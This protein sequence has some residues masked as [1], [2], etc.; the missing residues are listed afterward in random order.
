MGT[1]NAATRYQK[2]SNTTVVPFWDI[3]QFNV[4]YITSMSFLFPE[5][6]KVHS[7]LVIEL[8]R[9]PSY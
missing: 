6:A 5:D 4:G 9:V 2:S 1:C 3:G 7:F 8:L